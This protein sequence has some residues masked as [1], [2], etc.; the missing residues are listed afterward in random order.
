VPS[1]GFV[2]N[3]FT[4]LR[5]GPPDGDT[6][7]DLTDLYAFPSPSDPSRTVLILNCNTFTV[8]ADFHPDAVYRL[9]VDNNGDEATDLSFFVTFSQP[10]DGRQQATVYLAKGADAA[11][12]E[13][14]GE[15]LFKDV[16]VSFGPQPN[17]VT[18]G[19]YTFFAGRRSDAFFI[20]FAGILNMFDHK[21]GKNFTGLEGKPD[22]SRWTGKDLF[23]NQ[24]CF[25]M[26]F[27][28]PTSALGGS[29]GV[30]IWGR[31]SIRRDGQ[32]VP[33]DRS[34]HP[35]LANFFLTDEQKPAFNSGEPAQDR[36]RFLDAFL[37]SM[38]HVGGYSR[39]AALAA[40]DAEGLL[41]DMLRYDPSQPIGYPNGRRLTDHII[42]NR[43]HMLSNGTI[44]PDGLKPHTDLLTTFPFLGTPHASPDAA[45]AQGG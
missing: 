8:A 18:S 13:P 6:R 20:D 29:P 40:L 31:V 15:V 5:L 3:H 24:N 11:S 28:L 4:G 44:P 33:L 9:N 30:R 43:L 27:E 39:E 12:A 1:E 19:P 22:P 7:L 26:A 42:A 36:A 23:A 16:E 45:P 17:I 34:G 21:N 37:E 35:N 10:R 14:A 25:S 41:P 2:S 32:L 38:E